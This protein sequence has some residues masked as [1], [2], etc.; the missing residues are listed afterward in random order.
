MPLSRRGVRDARTRAL[1][2]AA[3]AASLTLSQPA[4]A[5]GLSM[6][7]AVALALRNNERARIA[8]LRV[9]Q[10]EG[11]VESARG[12][13]LPS[14]LVGGSANLDAHA[15][16]NGDHVSGLGTITLRQPILHPSAIPTYRASKMSLESSKQAAVEDE[17]ALAYDTA[18]AFVEA[19]AAERVLKAAEG[20]LERANADLEDTL[21]R[22]AA[23]L[24]S[25]NDSTR[26]KLDVASAK[27]GVTTSKSSVDRARL[28]LGLLLGTS[29]EGPL[30]EPDALSK[31]AESF[32]GRADEL[33]KTAR[34]ERA[35]LKKAHFDTLAARESAEEPLYRLAPTIDLNGVASA[36]PRPATGQHPDAET[37]TL[38]LSWTIF[39]G[40]VRYGDRKSKLAQA[41]SLAYQEKALERSVDIGVRSAVVSLL[42]AQEA[43]RVA[44]EA[45]EAARANSE[46]TQILYKQGLARAIE[47]T[48]ANASRFDAEVS[49][50]EARLDL[51]EAYLGLR[52]AEGLDPVD[53]NGGGAR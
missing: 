9:E 16:K 49:L 36:N 13:F 52:E 1:A 42:A 8:D 45:V 37:L 10:A 11:S 5:E 6:S 33:S 2:A 15:S 53:G 43:L 41:S 4:R 46:E 50:A 7:Q 12:A 47:L 19:V 26:T 35:D 21:A 48:D 17:R 27:R 51:V 14:L 18:R 40:G 31:A 44:E 20:R 24:N 39:D 38:S 34:V 25:S 30:E 32:V 28:S 3:F 29:V 22:V 23:Q